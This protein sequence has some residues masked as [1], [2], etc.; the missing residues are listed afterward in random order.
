MKKVI[1]IVPR[2]LPDTSAGGPIFATKNFTKLLFE[3]G[4]NVKL[5][6]LNTSNLESKF[7]KIDGINIIYYKVNK[8]FNNLSKSGWV[9][10][11]LRQILL[12]KL[13]GAMSF[14]LDL[15]E[16]YFFNYFYFKY[17]L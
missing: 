10:M 12:K 6:T 14:M 3:L 4:Y 17:F 15:L 16:L 7:G 5:L 8:I 11:I 1:I 9:F 13:N 2:Y